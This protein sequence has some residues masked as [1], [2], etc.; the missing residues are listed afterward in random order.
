MALLKSIINKYSNSEERSKETI[1]NIVLSMVMRFTNIISQLLIVNLTINYLN[2]ER[3]G[4]WLTLSSIIGWI[5]FL[6]LGL[7]NGF[8]N[9]FAEAKANN[10]ITLAKQ[11]LCTTYFVITIIVFIALFLILTANQFL[12]WTK[13]LNVN[14]DYKNELSFV[15]CLIISF[16][17]INM[18]V[19]IFTTMLVAD[20]K[21]GLASTIQAIGQ[22]GSLVAIYILTKTTEG[23][24]S[25]L[26]L[27]F[28]STPCI[29]TL[30]ASMIMFRIGRYKQ[31]CPAINMIKPSLTKNIINLGVQFF[32]IHL[33]MIAVFQ[34]INIVISRELGPESV[35]LFNVSNKYFNIIYMTAIIV[36]NPLWSA[37][38]DAYTKK[39]YQWMNSVFNKMHKGLGIAALLYTLLLLASNT[40]YQLWIGDSII[41]P[42]SVSSVMALFVFANT[43]GAI[44]M[45]LING[46]GT[47]RLQTITYILFAIVCWP[48]MTLAAHFGLEMVI[49]IPTLVYIVLGT[50][51]HIQLR[52]IINKTAKGIWA[53]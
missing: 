9:K 26:A 8:R 45:Y 20:Q 13:I 6:D 49:L 24:L 3:Y 12:D 48:I 16:T 43:Y 33:C 52:K 46:V 17:C 14:I 34:I 36:I 32:I 53:K 5:A 1:K 42:F 23:S 37:F 51:C 27:F 40:M 19:N 11:Y 30:A 2:P 44:N 18:V 28:S 4:I 15:F 10:D 38:T 22:V 29:V 50:I 41:I 25:N 39:D 47:V 7:G 21:P 31:F 35:T